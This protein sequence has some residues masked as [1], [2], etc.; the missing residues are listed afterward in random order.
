MMD[1]LSVDLQKIKSGE[2]KARAAILAKQQL[3]ALLTESCSFYLHHNDASAGQ[4]F[5][6]IAKQY[7]FI[8]DQ[9]CEIIKQQSSS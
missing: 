3:I 6:D 4:I 1:K 7:N 5:D 9:A 2:M 8:I